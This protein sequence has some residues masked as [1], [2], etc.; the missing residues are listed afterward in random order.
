MKG[1]PVVIACILWSIT[2]WAQPIDSQ[3]HRQMRTE[4]GVLEEKHF[5]ECLAYVYS[6]PLWVSY[7]GSLYFAP[8]DETTERQVEALKTARS[9]YVVLTNREARH[10]IAE[11]VI[12]ASGIDKQWQQKLLLPYSEVQQNLTPTL[13]R[14]FLIVNSYKMVQSV[15]EGDALLQDEQGNA[16]WVMDLGRGIPRGTSTN[17]Y[18]IKE[19]EK[20]F[21]TKAGDYQKVQAFS[22]LALSAEETSALN[23]VVAACQNK[24]SALAREL[25]G[26][27]AQQQF[28]D[29]KA[30]A[31]DNN[32]YMEYLLARCYLDGKGTERD[33]RL[34]MEWMR[35]AEKNGSGDAKT[36]L[37]GR[38]QAPN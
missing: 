19:G 3:A 4:R 15:D 11:S 21:A 12:A 13:N 8:K 31:T 38:G 34:G 2:L 23:R 1:R 24:A 37:Q 10:D 5:V 36:Y 30:R 29:L 27:K 35:K 25:T 14:P 16:F 32:P 18:L 7:R 28:A 17:L 6:P 9:R 26:F 22:N 33:E 20:A